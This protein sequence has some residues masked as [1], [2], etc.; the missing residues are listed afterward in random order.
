[1]KAS[2]LLHKNI[3]TACP[4][5]HKIRLQA[6]MAG[7]NSALTEQQVT[8]T[9]LG[10]NLKS[11]SKTST[12]HDIKRMDR[13]I[14]NKKLHKERDGIYRYLLTQLIGNQKHPILIADW[15]PIP[16]SKIFQLL[17][18]SIPMGGRSL[19]IYEQCYEESKLNFNS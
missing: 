14:G 13:L 19:T 16:G 10:R 6:L 8:V 12:K 1:M 7:V 5:M 11:Y 17:S 18:L 9:G 2:K 15:S 4:E 3:K